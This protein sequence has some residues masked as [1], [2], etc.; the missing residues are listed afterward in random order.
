MTRIIAYIALFIT[1]F[2]AAASL[3]CGTIASI[4]AD[5]SANR[6]ADKF[7][8][9]MHDGEVIL[10][11][12]PNPHPEPTGRLRMAYCT[13]YNLAPHAYKSFTATV[14]KVIDGDT[15]HVTQQGNEFRIRLW[16]IDAP[17]IDQP[18]GPQAKQFLERLTPPDSQITVNP[19]GL[20]TFGRLIATL[21]DKKSPS[22]NFVITAHGWAYHRNAYDAKGNYCLRRA[23]HNAQLT[24]SGV[25]GRNNN[26]MPPWE[27]RA[28]R[29]RHRSTD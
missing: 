25:W 9:A 1:G 16:G 4:V 14:L 5:P 19:I 17:E 28:N 22:T 24:H 11:N 13:A 8:S 2:I 29:K 6:T 26:N 27:Y 21:G 18:L 23:Q 15:I 10:P 7:L 20:D 3:T 12:Q